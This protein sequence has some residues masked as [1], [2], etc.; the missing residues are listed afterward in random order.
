MDSYYSNQLTSLPHFAGHYKQWGSGFG[1]IATEIGRVALPLARRFT[2]P[3]AKSIGRELI[4]QGVRALEL[5]D[6]VSK[7]K[8][9]KQA[10]KKALSQSS[11]KKNRRTSAATPKTTKRTNWKPLK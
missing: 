7:K 5:V 3:S 8:S 1:A 2:L 9:P 10:I 11:S 6:L 4:K